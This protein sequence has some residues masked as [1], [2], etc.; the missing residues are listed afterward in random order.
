MSLLKAV[1]GAFPGKTLSHEILIVVISQ[2]SRASFVQETQRTRGLLTNDART[3]NRKIYES[4]RVA[5]L[6]E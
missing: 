3:T 1:A 6:P 5:I 4:F 2:E